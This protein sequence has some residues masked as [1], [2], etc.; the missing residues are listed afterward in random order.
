MSM[1]AEQTKNNV[2][3]QYMHFS[4]VFIFFNFIEQKK[5]K[6]LMIMLFAI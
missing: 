1:Y 3:C 6:Q 4:V 2:C 5:N